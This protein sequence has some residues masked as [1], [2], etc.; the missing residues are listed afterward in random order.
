LTTVPSTN[1]IVEPRIATTSDQ[2]AFDAAGLGVGTTGASSHERAPRSSARSCC[3]ARQLEA[4]FGPF[5]SWLASAT[6]GS[7]HADVRGTALAAASGAIASGVGYSLWYAALRGLTTTRAAVVQ[8]S[9]PVLAAASAVV[10]LGEPISMRLALSGAS[11]LGG[12]AIV[13]RAR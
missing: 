12:I 2:R 13:L 3:A 10:F 7:A 11:I 9:V 4:S 6:T 5:A 1:A 8:L